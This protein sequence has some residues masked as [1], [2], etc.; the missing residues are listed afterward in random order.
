MKNIYYVQVLMIKTKSA[1]NGHEGG[2]IFIPNV[3]IQ[4]GIAFFIAQNKCSLETK[5][6][7]CNMLLS[8]Y[9]QWM[10]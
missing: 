3:N 7:T 6:L 8:V 2:P 10:E 1:C 5:I 9:Q 4:L